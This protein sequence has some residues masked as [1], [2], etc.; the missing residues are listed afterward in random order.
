MA[1]TQ[2]TRAVF[3]AVIGQAIRVRRVRAGLT[4]QELC[5]K[6]QADGFAV[7]QAYL[8]L[9]ENGKRHEISAGVL[10]SLHKHIGLTLQELLA[11]LPKH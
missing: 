4:Q 7:S 8:S 10:L 3:E 9:L 5:H 1:A 6:L 2:N 11:E